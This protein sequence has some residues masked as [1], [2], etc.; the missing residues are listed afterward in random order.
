MKFLMKW[1]TV[2]RP[3]SLSKRSGFMAGNVLL[4]VDMSLATLHTTAAAVAA[5]AA[6]TG[7]GAARRNWPKLCCDGAAVDVL[8][9]WPLLYHTS[10]RA[11]AMNKKKTFLTCRTKWNKN[12]N[13]KTLDKSWW[14]IMIIKR[15]PIW[16]W[17]VSACSHTARWW[18]Y[19]MT[20][21]YGVLVDGGRAK[22]HI[23]LVF[24]FATKTILLDFVSTLTMSVGH[25][26]HFKLGA[27]KSIKY[28]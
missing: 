2:K 13:P 28:I 23:A 19:H 27:R 17:L 18:S 9:V 10:K 1:Y 22:F 4:A 15:L 3:V 24:Y 16:W 25:T 12:R 11:V 20:C 14:T 6:A 21:Y 7:D 5:T 8:I 26:K